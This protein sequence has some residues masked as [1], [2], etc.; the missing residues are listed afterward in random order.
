M[1]ET[2]DEPLRKREPLANAGKLTLKVAKTCKTAKNGAFA[3]SGL[4]LLFDM[5]TIRKNSTHFGGLI[6]IF[7]GC[8]EQL[9]VSSGLT[10]LRFSHDSF[11]QIINVP[12]WVHTNTDRGFPRLVKPNLPLSFACFAC[13]R[14]SYIIL[15]RAGLTTF[16]VAVRA[17]P[18]VSQSCS[19]KHRKQNS[20]RLRPFELLSSGRG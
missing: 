18:W 3:A 9:K 6:Q 17:A 14:N 11:L 20:A 12:S 4:Q 8:C 10:Q 13:K 5:T 19:E 16:C 7:T 1:G 2:P 15:Y